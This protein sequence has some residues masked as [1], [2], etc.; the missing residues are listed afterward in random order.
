MM[1]GDAEWFCNDSLVMEA[2]RLISTIK[3][4]GHPRRPERLL[5][6]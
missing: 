3:D 1:F 4:D 6:S 2:V 5:F